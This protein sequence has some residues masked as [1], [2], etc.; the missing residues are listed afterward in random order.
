MKKIFILITI[1]LLIIIIP[2]LIPRKSKFYTTDIT[3]KY[4]ENITGSYPDTN[5]SMFRSQCYIDETLYSAERVNKNEKNGLYLNGIPYGFDME[6]E[7]P[8][9]IIYNKKLYVIFNCLVP[10]ENQERGIA[11]TEFNDWNPIFLQVENMPKNHWEKNWMPFV[12]NETLYFVYNCDPLV[13]LSYDFNND[14]ICKVVFT[15]N[16]ISLPCEIPKYLRG[17]TNLIHFK[18]D[19]YLGACHSIAIN[20]SIHIYNTQIILLDTKNW[21]IVYM[22]EPIMYETDDNTIQKKPGTNIIYEVTNIYGGLYMII[23]PCSIYM[24]NNK[25]YITVDISD[26]KTLLYELNIN[27]NIQMVE[28]EL[29]KLQELTHYYNE[30][31]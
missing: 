26:R 27:D 19:Y 30:G 7:D 28:Y 13:I 2:F 21:K 4:I 18:D 24:K 23:N 8:R 17:G 1:I 3:T 6:A 12:K 15:Q 31:H 25:T 20:N 9:L 10:F 11:I 5:Y 22:S 16:N 14:G 29:G